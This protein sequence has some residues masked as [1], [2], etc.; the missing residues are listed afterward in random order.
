MKSHKFFLFFFCFFIFL[1]SSPSLVFA[2]IIQDSGSKNLKDPI[3]IIKES[4]DVIKE[5]IFVTYKLFPIPI[6]W[7][8]LS[9]SLLLISAAAI[10]LIF[11]KIY[12]Q[13][14]RELDKTKEL[15]EQMRRE[16][17]SLKSNSKQDTE[18]ANKDL[19]EEIYRSISQLML[20]YEPAIKKVDQNPELRAKDMIGMLKPL[21]NFRDYMGLE[22]IGEIGQKTYFDET[23][24]VPTRK[25]TVFSNGDEITIEFVGYK[26][27]GNILDKAKVRQVAK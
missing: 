12:K 24:H 10:I 8:I 4:P 1:A 22:K 19:K 17:L 2:S 15:T 27:D 18:Q 26:M 16:Y 3:L 5:A 11:K 9:I 13:K 23:I 21:E 6:F 25:D 20:N 14:S 7:A